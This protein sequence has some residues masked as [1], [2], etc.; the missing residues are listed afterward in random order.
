MS[1]QTCSG[2]N[3][4]YADTTVKTAHIEV[5][6]RFWRYSSKTQPAAGLA[7]ANVVHR[8]RM[9]QPLSPPRA[10]IL[11]QR[12]R[13]PCAHGRSGEPAD[14]ADKFHGVMLQSAFF[15]AQSFRIKG[16]AIG[17]CLPRTTRCFNTSRLGL[18]QRHP[19]VSGAGTA[20]AALVQSF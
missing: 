10:L 7:C 8:L 14:G 11:E 5:S 18:A 1:R 20:A 17:C 19:F 9:S 4:P 6:H 13:V 15:S 3:R 2:L 16:G 12:P